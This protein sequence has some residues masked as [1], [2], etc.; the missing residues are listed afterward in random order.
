MEVNEALHSPPSSPY[1]GVI[2]RD[3]AGHHR[4]SNRNTLLPK[5]HC[6]PPLRGVSYEGNGWSTLGEEVVGLMGGGDGGEVPSLY[7]LH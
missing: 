2:V 1:G 6:S 4:R 7:N 3:T 5:S